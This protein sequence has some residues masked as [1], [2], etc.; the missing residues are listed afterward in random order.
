MDESFCQSFDLAGQERARGSDGNRGD[1]EDAAETGDKEEEREKNSGESFPNKDSKTDFSSKYEKREGENEPGMR[2]FAETAFKRGQLSSAVIAGTGKSMFVSCLNRSVGQE[3][4]KNR[5]ER[6]LFQKESLHRLIPG[7]EG[8]KL[9]VNRGEAESAVALVTDSL[10]DARWTLK[11]MQ[12]V[13]EGKMGSA[14]AETYRK[15]YPF[16][17]DK[18]EREL[19]DSY[20]EKLSK[21]SSETEKRALN[22]G[23]IK[24]EHVIEKKQQMKKRFLDHLRKLQYD[25][26]TAERMFSSEDFLN[27]IMQEEISTES[28]NDAGDN[29]END[30]GLF[31][32]NNLEE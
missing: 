14:G 17:T 9:I 28:G 25:A 6:K 32:G 13:A 5:K 12:D 11:S 16:L 30:S 20:K 8:S 3:N 22:S 26:L 1:T 18:K 4:A 10:K 31:E 29:D 15:Q 19:L 24:L 23:V 2:R 7:N 27:E 21:S